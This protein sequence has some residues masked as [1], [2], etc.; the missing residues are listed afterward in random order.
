MASI[1]GNMA[2]AKVEFCRDRNKNLNQKVESAAPVLK[3]LNVTKEQ[4]S[5]RIFSTMLQVC[6][7]KDS[8]DGTQGSTLMGSGF[9]LQTNTLCIISG[10]MN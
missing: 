1:E 8:P 10:S 9:S 5:E 6:R 4:K 7:M 2:K 3:K